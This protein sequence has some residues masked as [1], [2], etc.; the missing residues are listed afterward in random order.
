MARYPRTAHLA[1][2]I[3][4]DGS[5]TIACSAAQ[6]NTILATGNEICWSMP[7]TGSKAWPMDTGA[8]MAMGGDVGVSDG[9]AFSTIVLA[10]TGVQI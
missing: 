10:N 9:T 5:P 6:A 1:R 7:I 4:A 2:S 3:A 8:V